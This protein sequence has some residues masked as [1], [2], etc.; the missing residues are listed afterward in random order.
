MK[1]KTSFVY[2]SLV[3]ALVS[4]LWGCKDPVEEPLEYDRAALLENLASNYIVPAYAEFE[5]KAQAVETALA[6]FKATTD[7]TNVAALRTAVKE[8]WLAWERCSPFGFG[9]AADLNLRPALNTFPADPM[10]IESNVTAGAWD[11]ASA[12]NVDARGFPSLDYLL[13]HDTE[14]E[15]A[16][17]FT[18]ATDAANRLQLLEDLIM[19]LVNLATSVNASW[20]SY[21]STFTSSLG[22]DA[23]SSTAQ[24]VNQINFDLEQTKNGRVGIPLGKKSLGQI[25]PEK[26][27]AYYGGYSSELATAHIRAIR[28]L[29]EGR[30]FANGTDGYGL[31]EALAALQA[32]YNG[33]SLADAIRGQLDLAVD[34]T[35]ALPDPLHEA[36]S[37]SNTAP[38][39]TAHT[40]LQRLVVIFKT[41][42]PSAL[43]IL[44]TYADN[45]GD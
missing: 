32:D 19:D 39:E 23:G 45:D 24:F 26:V 3:L 14:A 40:E 36:I 7:E 22:T 13:N 1:R 37:N 29:Y 2:Y 31:Y 11:L 16:I 17:D 8:A 18:T 27:E 41:D 12:A 15:I 5:T 43:S 30:S 42:M 4:G 44:I 28:D 38:V 10:Q 25:L 9:P 33:Q 35:Q 21:Q 6:D 20:Q 34:A